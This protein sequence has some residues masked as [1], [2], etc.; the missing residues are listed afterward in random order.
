M[1]ARVNRATQSMS[2]NDLRRLLAQ[3]GVSPRRVALA[4]WVESSRI[5]SVIITLILVNAVVLGLETS[6]RLRET[7]GGWLLLVDRVCLASFVAELA[8]KIVA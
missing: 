2:E 8:I 7:W 4:R 6:A 5:Q 3:P 1:P